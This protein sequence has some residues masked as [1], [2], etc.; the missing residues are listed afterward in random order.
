M[1]LLDSRRVEEQPSSLLGE[2]EETHRFYANSLRERGG[3]KQRTEGW[4]SMTLGCGC[5]AKEIEIQ[6][7]TGCTELLLLSV[8]PMREC[9]DEVFG[10]R[11]LET[12]TVVW[13]PGRQVMPRRVIQG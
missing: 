3:W 12:G 13:N 7:R 11:R 1:Q 6:N 4:W 8:D 9:L 2:L 5:V 10:L